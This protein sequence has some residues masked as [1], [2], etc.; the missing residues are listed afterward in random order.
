MSDSAKE[1]LQPASISPS[2]VS[3]SLET[4]NDA[5]RR[6]MADGG[7]PFQIEQ[8][9]TRC[10]IE[11]EHSALAA[12]PPP[13]P[14]QETRSFL[15]VPPEPSG[16]VD[17]GW[18]IRRLEVLQAQY[19][20]DANNHRL[21]SFKQSEALAFAE[22]LKYALDLKAVRAQQAA[23]CRKECP[24]DCICSRDMRSG[25]IPPAGMYA[26]QAEQIA[27]QDQQIL[28]MNAEIAAQ[29]AKLEQ[30]EARLAH[31]ETTETER[32]RNLRLTSLT[33]TERS[34]INETMTV[35]PRTTEE[36]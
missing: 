4:V 5:I 7:T 1:H 29:A 2:R 30:L 16:S 17:T 8:R 27:D 14:S 31:Q 18:M 28:C 25:G 33:P 22:S 21:G 26:Q 36:P 13:V 24:P 19:W 32:D 10:F 20:L 34:A 6:I 9:L 15:S 35:E 3:G 12:A 11:R 23:K